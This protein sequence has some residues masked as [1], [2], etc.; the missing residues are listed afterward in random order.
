MAPLPVLLS[1]S[2]SS[3]SAAAA[4][5]SFSS[6]SLSLSSSTLS[7]SSASAV[8]IIIIIII[9]VIIMNIIIIVIIIIILVV[10]V[11]II[12]NVIIITT[13]IIIIINVIIITVIITIIIIIIIISVI[14]VIIIII[15]IVFKSL[16]SHFCTDGWQGPLCDQ[17]SPYPG[18]LH[19]TCREP[20]ECNCARN[21]GGILCNKDLNYCGT[22]QPC[23]N[24]GICQNTK[25]DEYSC[26]CS[27]GFSGGN[28][29]IVDRDC[30]TNPCENG[31]TCVIAANGVSCICAPGWT[32]SLCETDIDECASNP[33]MN[34]GW[35]ENQV[36][37]YKCHCRPGW[38][39]AQCQLDV[40]EC[41][42]STC[43]NAIYC[44]NLQGSYE[45][46]CQAGWT[47]KNCDM[48]ILS[49]A[50]NPFFFFFVHLCVWVYLHVYIIDC[51]G[52]C[53]N[54]AT[55]VN[56]VN[57]YRCQCRP[58]FTGRHCDAAINGC[59]SLPCL[60]GG[61]C[62]DLN[63]GFRC[64]CPSGYVGLQCQIAINSCQ[65]NPCRSGSTCYDMRGDFYCHC[66][67]GFEGKTCEKKKKICPN[68]SCEVIDQCT[69]S[70]PSNRTSGE[71]RSISSNICGKHGIC[72]SQAGSG[73]VCEC[74][75]GYQGTYCH[76]NINDC[77][78]NPCQNHGICTDRVNGFRC[79]CPSG[80]K[81]KT[82]S[83]TSWQSC[84]SNPCQKGG[85]C[86]NS[87][88]S[89]TCFC[90]EGFEGNVCE[91]NI[92]DC[93][94]FPCYNGAQCIDGVNWYLCE[95]SKGFAGP[96]C[97]IN[98]Q[99]CTS[100]PCAFGSTCIDE[101]GSYKCICPPGRT[102][103][104]CENVIGHLPS[105]NSCIFKQHV[106]SDKSS[107]QHE[108]NSCHC[109]DGRVH[110]TKVW[111]GPKNCLSHP[112]VSEPVDICAHDET[113]VVKTTQTCFTPPCLPW[114]HCKHISKI[115]DSAPRDIQTNCI[116]NEAKIS[117]NCAKINLLFDKSRMPK[118]VSVGNICNSLR[119]F[120]KV[121]AYAKKE[122]IIILCAIQLRRADS[123]EITLSMDI[124]HNDNSG[125]LISTLKDLVEETANAVSQKL[126]NSSALKAV[127]DVQVETNVIPKKPSGNNYTPVIPILCAV[128]GLLGLISIILLIFWYRRRWTS[129]RARRMER[130]IHQ[131]TNNEN[132][133]ALTHFQRKSLFDIDKGGGGGGGT[134]NFL[135]T[136]FN[137]IGIEKYEKVSAPKRLLPTRA[138]SYEKL[139]QKTP[140]RKM[141]K[142]KD[143]NI[144]ISRTLAAAAAAEREIIM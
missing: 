86:V 88:D 2:S 73:F 39:G 10:I 112:N 82:C 18:C 103:N 100:N 89:F 35:C 48:R 122:T 43:V 52:Q 51:V 9:F 114:G 59:H 65:Q 4:L 92:N 130:A 80:W 16:F 129:K 77:S 105:P 75:S 99:E 17:C 104:Q 15:I 143:I 133:E 41:K 44:R 84:N 3:L 136:E 45:C 19:G 66:Q 144:E 85:T 42:D 25:P 12:I 134:S 95:C 8:V 141:T 33:C 55:C 28:C 27:K 53:H 31:G 46:Q 26:T 101:I 107:W 13:T 21:W 109:N 120:P 115:E 123:I 20:W 132:E 87:G 38:Q 69:I 97:R 56:L 23:L 127:I 138:D 50:N 142:K 117:N 57:D 64:E 29:E 79:V 128:V 113:C 81:G 5:S 111:C 1:L 83:S 68:G 11:V 94:P 124:K 37:G 24:G 96:N 62:Y 22:Y 118:G 40:D 106:Y 67:P 140:L 78:P 6:S 61:V 63:D 30:E 116:P 131:K 76:E 139:K 58:G 7:S 72:R 70:V 110:C 98:L 108:C 49:K 91:K 90:K 32:G 125:I 54:G 71:V 60:N 14:L 121:Q 119:A 135:T 102:G 36:N 74:Q 126:V 47:G 93:Y 34:N 137:E